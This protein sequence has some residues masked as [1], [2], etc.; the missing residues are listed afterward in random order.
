MPTVADAKCVMP[1]GPAAPG[2]GPTAATATGSTRGAADRTAF[3]G[4]T[5]LQKALDEVARAFAGGGRHVTAAEREGAFNGLLKL[6]IR[7][8]DE[9]RPKTL[10]AAV[11]EATPHPTLRQCAARAKGQRIVDLPAAH[12]RDGAA[13]EAAER[14][15]LAL[16][17]SVTDRALP[18]A[19]LHLWVGA[20][21]ML[22]LDLNPGCGLYKGQIMIVTEIAQYF[23]TVRYALVHPRFSTSA[24]HHIPRVKFERSIAG[25]KFWRRQYPLKLAYPFSM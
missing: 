12:L 23:L 4:A 6:C 16:M 7:Y 15:D 2:N 8:S 19:T 9:P 20:R 18:P 10:L 21:V 22:L 3:N 1:T 25:V 13:N 11:I 24:P 14:P 5:S 17:L